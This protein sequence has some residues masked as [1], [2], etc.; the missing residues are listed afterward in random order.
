M[1]IL[2]PYG[3]YLIR[4]THV[5]PWTS[6]RKKKQP[7]LFTYPWGEKI[8]FLIL[9]LGRSEKD[10]DSHAFLLG[11]VLLAVRIF[12]SQKELVEQNQL[13]AMVFVDYCIQ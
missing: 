3:S 2:F 9:F 8:T 6:K 1:A 11:D 13:H 12:W 5:N 7:N 4:Y 10:P